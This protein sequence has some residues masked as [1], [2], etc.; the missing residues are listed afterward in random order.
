MLMKKHSWSFSVYCSLST[1]SIQFKGCKI[2]FLEHVHIHLI[3]SS[4]YAGNL[5]SNLTSPLGTI[6]KLT[7][8]RPFDFRTKMDVVITSVHF[9][10]E[11]S[12]GIWTLSFGLS[13]GG[14]TT[15]IVHINIKQRSCRSTINVCLLSILLLNWTRHTS[16]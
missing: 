4:E 13:D 6:S 5:V 2:D 14:N 1:V 10:G 8:G 16:I 12:N 3:L 7:A 15:G 9:W 11:S